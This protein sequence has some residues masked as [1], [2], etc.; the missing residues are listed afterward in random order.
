MMKRN[1]MTTTQKLALAYAQK[2]VAYYESKIKS[3]SEE[4]TAYREMC[5][6]QNALA[7]EAEAEANYRPEYN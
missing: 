6:A 2:L 5:D 4:R 1:N 7:Y 3:E